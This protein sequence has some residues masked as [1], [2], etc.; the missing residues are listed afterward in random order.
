MDQALI[1][2][3]IA[4][5]LELASRANGFVEAQAP[6]TL[7]KDS[8]GDPE[9]DATLSSLARALLVL[10]TLF[11]PILPAKMEDLA[12]RLGLKAVPTLAEARDMDLAGH[13]VTRGD[14]LFPRADLQKK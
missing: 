3:G 9:L 8:E 4:V 12:N 7:A 5:A 14:P 13:S 1:H 2:Q 6:W 11:Q 10:A